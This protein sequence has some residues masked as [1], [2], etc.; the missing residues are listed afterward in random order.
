ML[1]YRH[2]DAAVG[3][4]HHVASYSNGYESQIPSANLSLAKS[5]I[6]VD[7]QPYTLS[8]V[9]NADSL[10][11]SNMIVTRDPRFEATFQSVPKVQSATLICEQVHRQNYPWDSGNI[12][13]TMEVIPTQTMLRNALLEV[14]LN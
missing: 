6:A 8:T 14:L 5:F 2:Y 9:E 10:N 3:V 13:P 12:P 1:M 7:G 4:T 11:I